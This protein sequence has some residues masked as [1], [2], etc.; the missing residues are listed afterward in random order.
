M[1]EFGN[2]LK[3]YTPTYEKEGRQLGLE[4]AVEYALD[5]DK[6]RKKARLTILYLPFS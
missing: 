3:L 2:S 1:Q 4:K 6:D 5:F